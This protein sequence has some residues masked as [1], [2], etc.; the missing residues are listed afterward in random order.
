MSLKMSSTQEKDS[1]Q[2]KYGVKQGYIKC[3]KAHNKPK[4][5]IIV[6][7]CSHI[8]QHFKSSFSSNSDSQV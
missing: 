4:C 1:Y 6:K 7:D 8:P 2:A 5:S 3:C